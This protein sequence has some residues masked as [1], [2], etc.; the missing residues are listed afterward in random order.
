MDRS[1]EGPRPEWIRE[2]R[3][4]PEGECLRLSDDAWTKP[5]KAEAT[6]EEVADAANLPLQAGSGRARRSAIQLAR[7]DALSRNQT[8]RGTLGAE[9]AREPNQRLSMMLDAMSPS[10]ITTT[11]NDVWIADNGH[12][13]IRIPLVRCRAAR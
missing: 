2:L 12:T 3:K 8:H 5:R 9:P 1:T 10:A 11:S 7:P 13:V 6:P 4:R